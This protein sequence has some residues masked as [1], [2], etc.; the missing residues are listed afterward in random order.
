MQRFSEAWRQQDQ[1]DPDTR[2]QLKDK[3]T[4][5]RNSEGAKPLN[6]GEAPSPLEQ[7]NSQQELLR[8]KLYREILNE[9]KAAQQQAQKDPQICVKQIGLVKQSSLFGKFLCCIALLAYLQVKIFHSQVDQ[10]ESHSVLT[11][12]HL[13]A[14]FLRFPVLL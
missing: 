7:V 9:E 5:L 4:F 10:Q 14:A 6:A 2:Q 3:L 1:L 12:S 13:L 8:Q 11:L